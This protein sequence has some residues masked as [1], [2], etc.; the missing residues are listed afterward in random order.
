[1]LLKTCAVVFCV[2]AGF[3]CMAYAD[4][5]QTASATGG[6]VA[7]NANSGARV[8][9]DASKK[10]YNLNDKEDLKKISKLE[11]E[12]SHLLAEISRLSLGGEDQIIRRSR[13]E[14][15]KSLPPDLQQKYLAGDW[16]PVAHYLEASKK[17]L[18]KKAD[19]IDQAR[20]KVEFE[21]AYIVSDSEPA[22]ALEHLDVALKLDPQ[23]LP[24]AALSVH[25]MRGLGRFE[26]VISLVETLAN[27][28][29][30]ASADKDSV[31][32][33]ERLVEQAY[34]QAVVA[35]LRVG[36]KDLAIQT[37]KK[38]IGFS[39]FAAKAGFRNQADF[40]QTLKFYSDLI[41]KGDG[42]FD[43]MDYDSIRAVLEGVD[44][45]FGNCD[46]CWMYISTVAAYNLMFLPV[47]ALM[48]Q[49]D[50]AD[51]AFE[52][53]QKILLNKNLPTSYW[54]ELRY[55]QLIGVGR[56]R[57]INGDKAGEDAY[58]EKA[59]D[60]LTSGLGSGVFSSERYLELAKLE[61]K[62]LGKA[63][64]RKSVH[65]LNILLTSASL[66]VS[67]AV[68]RTKGYGFDHVDLYILLAKTC[69]DVGLRKESEEYLQRA[70]QILSDGGSR[71]G[72]VRYL[73]SQAQIFEMRGYQRLVE[74]DLGGAKKMAE[75]W[76]KNF[77][78]QN[79]RGIY[80]DLSEPLEL[81][82]RV[83]L[84][85]EGCKDFELY[86][87]E[88]LRVLTQ[89]LELNKN[90]L[91]PFLRKQHLLELLQSCSKYDQAAWERYLEFFAY[92]D[93]L[94]QYRPWDLEVVDDMVGAIYGLVISDLAIRQGGG[95]Y[96]YAELL[97][98]R[99]QRCAQYRDTAARCSAY[100]AIALALIGNDRINKDSLLVEASL[101]EFRVIEKNGWLDQKGRELYMS[102]LT[103]YAGA[104]DWKKDKEKYLGL[105]R[106]VLRIY[107]LIPEKERTEIMR[108][109]AE[110]LQQ[111]LSS[112]PSSKFV[113]K[114]WWF[115][116][117][118]TF[119][120]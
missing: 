29:W 94:F 116:G 1:M 43:S 54:Y 104:L 85:A 9:V 26:D 111:W 13:Q 86:V 103:L 27:H 10:T 18:E 58:L 80:A 102:A 108:R 84:K 15:I 6:G 79:A 76:R 22:R 95:F 64:S 51:N 62:R 88:G 36:R 119:R 114:S 40:R 11:D 110:S 57:A 105:Q 21:L 47:A 96:Y 45:S 100:S 48:G 39:S 8:F 101:N 60:H 35:L 81:S 50:V 98:N 106:E 107:D 115:L 71:S 117:E 70:E 93:V 92:S 109:W 52:R 66:S 97:R 53:T 4:N 56:S 41:G 16:E 90:A 19:K 78:A 44:Y 7:V 87:L 59:I 25:L 33:I 83:S 42:V 77:E 67:N 46:D 5:G 113:E 89:Y 75:S 28:A 17:E 82:A 24:A 23:N 34:I 31:E 55:L 61:I 65:P 37:I 120:E 99:M 49:Q 72:S 32:E 74:G 38:G 3:C 68:E 2:T 69:S 73:E 112:H 63:R 12:R 14:L 30:L 118:V 20:S 91:I